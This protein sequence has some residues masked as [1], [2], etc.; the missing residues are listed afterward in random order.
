MCTND[1]MPHWGD[2]ERGE[3][4]IRRLVTDR[5][6]GFIRPTRANGTTRKDLFFHAAQV[7]GVRYEELR[8]DDIVSYTLADDGHGKGPVATNVERIKR[9]PAVGAVAHL[10]QSEEPAP[11]RWPAAAARVANDEDS[12]YDWDQAG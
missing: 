1:N 2:A 9:A 3:G 5:G 11:G 7:V 4:T 10:P 12:V 8:E 6:F